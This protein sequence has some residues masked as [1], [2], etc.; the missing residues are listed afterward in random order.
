MPGNMSGTDL[1]R[2]L[3]NENPRLRVIYMSGYSIEL[4]GPGFSLKE[5][6]N[7]LV[8]PFQ[9]DKLAVTVRARLDQ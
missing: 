4:A 3:L 8:K 1:A 7:F 2:V 5:G 6:V 9:A